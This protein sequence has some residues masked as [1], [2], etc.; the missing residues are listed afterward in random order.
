[1][2][3]TGTAF[4]LR[5]LVILAALA[6]SPA[7]ASAPADLGPQLVLVASAVPGAPRPDEGPTDTH[8]LR[9]DQGRV[10]AVV[11]DSCSPA[12]PL[13]VALA[14]CDR[15]ELASDESADPVAV[16]LVGLGW[17]GR[18]DGPAV[19]Q[20]FASRAAVESCVAGAWSSAPVEIVA[21]GDL[22]SFR[23]L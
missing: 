14:V 1:M 5:L 11:P 18:V 9:D 6:V 21:P 13:A 16:C 2:T 3:N 17:A 8:V 10:L 19:P 22:P 4:L 20:I 7:A 23:V 15:Y 12:L